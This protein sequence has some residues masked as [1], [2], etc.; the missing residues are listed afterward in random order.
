[1][2]HNCANKPLKSDSPRRF[3]GL[4]QPPASTPRLWGRFLCYCVAILPASLSGLLT[5]T[6]LRA[7]VAAGGVGVGAAS[8]PAHYR[9]AGTT[10]QLDC[11]G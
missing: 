7:G 9:R 8:A 10:S 5:A 3:V 11:Y 1:M 2:Q 6:L 4:V